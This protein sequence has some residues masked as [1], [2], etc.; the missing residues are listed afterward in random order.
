MSAIGGRADSR[1][2]CTLVCLV[3]TADQQLLRHR[4]HTKTSSSAVCIVC[5]GVHPPV[6]HFSLHPAMPAGSE[7]E[8]DR[9]PHMTGDFG[10]KALE[11][12]T[13]EGSRED[14]AYD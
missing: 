12:F 3:P 2:H 13:A 6:G 1:R 4:G 14:A 5:R 10:T 11:V 8:R 9:A 7:E